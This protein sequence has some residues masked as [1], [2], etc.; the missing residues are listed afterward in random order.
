MY[1]NQ[2]LRNIKRIY[3]CEHNFSGREITR[4]TDKW[5]VRE[6]KAHSKYGKEFT[7][8][9][10]YKGPKAKDEKVKAEPRKRTVDDWDKSNINRDD[11]ANFIAMLN[12]E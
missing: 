1:N 8:K 9:E 10:H 3:M 4:H 5:L 12:K 11:I 2:P 6:H 7:R